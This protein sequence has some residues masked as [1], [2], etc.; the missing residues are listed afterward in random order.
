MVRVVAKIAK[1]ALCQSEPWTMHV[2]GETLKIAGQVDRIDLAA[3][4]DKAV[5]S[6]IDYKTGKPTCIQGSRFRDWIT[7]TTTTVCLGCRAIPLTKD[8]RDRLAD[9]L[10]ERE[11]TK[12]K[13][14]CLSELIEG[15]IR[16]TE[17]WR[18]E[19][20]SFTATRAIVGPW[21]PTWRVS[22]V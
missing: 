5:F 15:E 1:D 3:V 21:Y 6:I 17:T 18:D 16:P 9:W 11:R 19:R 4:K 2:A 20:G 14:V 7:I 22:H 12:S 13:T 10:L 8:G